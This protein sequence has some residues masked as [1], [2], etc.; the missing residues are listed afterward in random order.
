MTACDG[1]RDAVAG[2][3]GDHLAAIEMLEGVGA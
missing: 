1:C 2:M 3:Y